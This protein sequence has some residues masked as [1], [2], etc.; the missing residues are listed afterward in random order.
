M[1]EALM[2][3]GLAD[4]VWTDPPY[5]IDYVGE[6]KDALRIQ[7]DAATDLD[8]LPGGAFASMV[9]VAR[10]GV[11]VYITHADSERLRFET[12]LRAAGRGAGPAEPSLG[13]EHHRDGLVRLPRRARADRV[14]AHH[15]P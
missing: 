1:I 6:T 12:T 11:P 8:D 2:D 10:P 7:G 14:Q 13:E 9:A 5:G 4:C 3:G 15:W